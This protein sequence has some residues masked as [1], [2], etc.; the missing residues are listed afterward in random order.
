[1]SLVPPQDVRDF[2]TPRLVDAAQLV[3]AMNVVAGW[4]RK[5]AGLAVPPDDLVPS[6]PLY[7]PALELT[8]LVAANPEA[9]LSRGLGPQ[10]QAMPSVKRRREI[11]DEVAEDARLAALQARGSFPAPSAWPDPAERTWPR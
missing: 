7:A 2:L 5:A 4:L 9:L 6:D 1:M 11:L 8:A 3:V 10:Q